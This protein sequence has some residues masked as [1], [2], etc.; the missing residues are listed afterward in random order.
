MKLRYVVALVTSA[1]VAALG[2]AVAPSVANA[3][4]LHGA[5]SA[6]PTLREFAA[7]HNGGST[8][9]VSG[10]GLSKSGWANAVR[11]P[12]FHVDANGR[13]FVIDSAALAPSA[14]Q[15]AAAGTP[16]DH[17]AISTDNAFT[18]HSD[19]G[20][21]RT[22]YLDFTGMD[23]AGTAWASSGAL[24]GSQT[25]IAPYDTDGNGSTFS[26]AERQVIIDAWSAVAEDYSMF[27]VD[28]TT[29]EPTQ[30]Q[31]DRSSSSDQVYGTRALITSGSNAVQDSCGGCGGIAY[32]GTYNVY[33]VPS[34][35]YMPAFAFAQSWFNGK[36][37]SDIV[38]HEVGHN[39]G[40]SH[41]GYTPDEYYLGRSG[42]APIMG[43]GYYQPL[44]QWSNGDY[45]SATQQQDDFSVM[46][47]YGVSLFAD[48][49]GN[50]QGTANAISA[51]SVTNGVITT[52]SDVDFYS[53]VAVK[54]T[55]DIAVTSPSISS[56]LDVALTVYDASGNVLATSNPSMS[57]IDNYTLVGL[58]ASLTANVTVGS[59]YYVKI[60]GVGQ[61]DPATT[62]YSDYGSVGQ[63]VL[64][65]SH[66]AL[67]DMTA[68]VPS[69]S[70]SGTYGTDLIG[71]SGTWPTGAT[72]TTEWLRNGVGT[73]DTDSTF[74]PA[75]SDVGVEIALRVTATKTDYNDVT[76][77][78]SPV[79][80]T[81][82]SMSLTPTP[83]VTGTGV[84]GTALT[85]STG[86]WDAGVT[87]TTTWMRN[88]VATSQHGSTY[89]PNVNDLGVPISFRVVGT[90]SGYSA[91][92]KTS[93][94]VTITAA[95]MTP[96]AT[97]TIVGKAKVGKL[98]TTAVGT[99]MTSVTF[100]YQWLRN[101]T[102][103][104]GATGANYK[105]T[106]KDKGRRISVTV[107]GSRAGYT[108]VTLTSA[109]TAKVTS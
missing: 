34:N 93:S 62:G 86:T 76:V 37:I 69:V 65:L 72:V 61:G 91:V 105:L 15:V 94:P 98:L 28:V 26:T 108:P 8:G 49:A 19:P 109:P 16:I 64:T 43:A 20:S 68:G 46:A 32:V 4:G 96:T 101:G 54:A 30:A 83:T 35:W 9:W 36:I 6:R 53:F 1:A 14:A 38:S 51:A 99:W 52:R 78:T 56:D 22:I 5:L 45:G 23:I 41:D 47:S 60:D 13:A 55:E 97:P 71:S 40:L 39:L 17:S 90:K 27:D 66:S 2:T 82:A 102:A 58:D 75:A 21:N 59:T 57:R 73:G 77:T 67:L 24:T 81:A 89:T 11:D 63:Y 12:T 103:I 74:S 104:S 29:Q 84:F 80:I 48:D 95:T 42:W 79:T 70:G 107:I 106:T 18:L 31:L 100:T 50:T 33:G 10:T 88:G 85:G 7:A 92:T 87:L 25:N 3:N 44:V